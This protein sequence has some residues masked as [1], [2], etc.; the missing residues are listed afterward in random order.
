MRGSF[1]AFLS[2]FTTCVG[3]ANELLFSV[4]CFCVDFLFF[5]F[6]RCGG[7]YSFHFCCYGAFHVYRY[8]S[9]ELW[10][11]IMSGSFDFFC[12]FNIRGVACNCPGFIRQ[13]AFC[14][15][16][17]IKDRCIADYCPIKHRVVKQV[18]K[19]V[20]FV[21]SVLT[22]INV[23]VLTRMVVYFQ[24]IPSNFVFFQGSV[25]FSLNREFNFFKGL[26]FQVLA[27]TTEVDQVFLLRK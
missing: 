14:S 26:R 7:E 16:A 23:F 22:P 21:P 10:L 3:A 8:F 9:S 1:R 24:F 19:V 5:Q 20:P 11:R 4:N 25:E 17:C 27:A 12:Q 6:Y 2:I 18:T 15:R 13:V